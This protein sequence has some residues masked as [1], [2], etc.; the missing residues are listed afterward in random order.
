MAKDVRAPA[1][2]LGE[3]TAISSASGK[4]RLRCQYLEIPRLTRP[5]KGARSHKADLATPNGYGRRQNNI[6][7]SATGRA[8]GDWGC[9]SSDLRSEGD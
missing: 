5:G 6:D 3:L 2:F 8:S 9:R 7:N 1:L 4:L